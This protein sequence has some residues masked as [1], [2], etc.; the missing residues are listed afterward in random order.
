MWKV[1]R[2]DVHALFARKVTHDM[3]V[4]SSPWPD[5]TSAENK[6]AL[7]LRVI[8]KDLPLAVRERLDDVLLFETFFKHVPDRVDAEA[9]VPE[10]H[11]R[12][13]TF[14]QIMSVGHEGNV[15]QRSRRTK[16]KIRF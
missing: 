13:D 5:G 4:G 3:E 11:Q 10:A 16:R 14:Q 1:G 7:L 9:I 12:G 8:L 6:A 15:T 2:D